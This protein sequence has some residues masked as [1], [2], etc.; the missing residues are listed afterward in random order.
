MQKKTFGYYLNVAK[1]FVLAFVVILVISVI[2]DLSADSRKYA[3]GDVSLLVRVERLKADVQFLTAI[4]PSRNY[5]NPSSL[6]KASAYIFKKFKQCTNRLK[7]QTYSVA[8]KG[9]A[10]NVEKRTGVNVRTGKTS[11]SENLYKN[12]IASFGPTVDRL[13]RIVVG[14]HYDVCGDQP[15]ADDNGSGVAVVLELARLFAALKPSLSRRIDLV[16]YTLEEPPFFRTSQ[17]GSA[18]HARSLAEA[19]V[20]VHVM[21]SVDMIGYFSK[22]DKPHRLFRVHLADE[23]VVPGRSTCLIGRTGEEELSRTIGNY[24]M[25]SGS[26][27]ENITPLH[28][29]MLNRKQSTAGF[30]YSDHLNFWKNGYPAVMLTNFVVCSGSYYHTK[31]DTI[32]KLNFEMLTEIVKRLYRTLIK[33]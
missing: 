18:V 4:Q 10:K 11:D 3:D 7:Y 22:T 1:I 6:D 5:L 21:I 17:M 8:L 27:K 32:E 16:T 12:V 28:V 26:S 14:A 2:I 13:P 25:A 19:N 31:R 30:D 15:G 9:Q 23:T 33:L 29:V 20:D 24:M